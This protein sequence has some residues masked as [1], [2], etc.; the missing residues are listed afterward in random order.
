MLHVRKRPGHQYYTVRGTVKVGKETRKVE[1]HSTGATSAANAREYAAALEEEIRQ[2]ILYPGRR[3]NSVTFGDCTDVYLNRPE[4][5]GRMDMWRILELLKWFEDTPVT[6]AEILSTWNEFK[7]IRCKGNAPATINRFQSTLVAVLNYAS[8]NKYHFIVPRIKSLKASNEIV[9]FLREEQ[10]D[11]LLSCYPEYAYPI[12]VMFCYNGN[13]TQEGLQ[14]DWANVNLAQKTIYFNRT[15][16]GKPRLVPMH[17]KVYCVLKTLWEKRGRPRTGH[18]F[19]NSRGAPYQ[20]TR[21]AKLPG[22]NPLRSVHGTALKK[23]DEELLKRGLSPIEEFRVHDWRHHFACTCIMSGIDIETIKTIGGWKSIRS[24][25]RY[26]AVSLNHTQ[27][28][29]KKLA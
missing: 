24:L 29:I 6:Q 18:V 1:E 20:D 4:G 14:L 19:L 17:P 28:Q 3:K 23:A 5:I 15:K 16:N 26:M 9:R 11:V 13:R 25:E 10:K 7:D 27:E 22:G 8:A 21:D 12:F 2:S